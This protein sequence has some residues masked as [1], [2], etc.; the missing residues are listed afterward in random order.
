MYIG[1][2][3]GMWNLHNFAMLEI[4]F[5]MMSYHL[6]GTNDNRLRCLVIL[7]RQRIHARLQSQT[8]ISNM[9]TS[10]CI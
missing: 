8:H 9:F 3:G 4:H 7:L 5:A 10:K 2:K 6:M 1:R